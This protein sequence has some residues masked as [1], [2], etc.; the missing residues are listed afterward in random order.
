M[1]PAGNPGGVRRTLDGL[2]HGQTHTRRSWFRLLVDGFLRNSTH[3]KHAM[4]LWVPNAARERVDHTSCK[5]EM[6]V[7]VAIGKQVATGKKKI[8]D[9]EDEILRL[10]S[11]ST[12]SLLDDMHLV[13]TLQDSKTISEEVTQQLQVSLVSRL[14]KQT[15]GRLPRELRGK[16]VWTPTISPPCCCRAHSIHVHV[17]CSC[18][19]ALRKERFIIG[20]SVYSPVSRAPSPVTARG[21]F[22]LRLLR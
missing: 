19:I 10:L 11:E 22:T 7:Y 15:Y 8:A 9:L 16:Y 18:Q 20:V 2:S 14:K 17:R 3:K 21:I 13:N 4:W 12:G 6:H 1:L 5:S